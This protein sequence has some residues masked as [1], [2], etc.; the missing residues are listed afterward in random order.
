MLQLKN[1]TPFGSG[2]SVFYDKN[3]VDTLHVMVSAA[4]NISRKW[5]LLDEQPDP[6]GADEYWGDDPE[7]SSII[8]ASDYHIGKP[9]TDIV[10][11]GHA[12]APE[13]KK[14]SQLDVGLQ[15]GKLSKTIRVFGDRIWEDGRIGQADSFESIPLI[16]ERAFGGQHVEEGQVISAEQRNLVGCGYLGKQ[17]ARALDGTPVPNL[18]DPRQLL[19]KAGDVAPPAGFGF[20]SPGWEPRVAYAGTYDDEWKN[21]RA[22]FLPVDFDQRYLSMAHPELVYPGYL[23][24]GEEVGI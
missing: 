1:N 5:T 16:Y 14:V 7:T 22:P 23:Q 8:Y 13:G 6:V 17:K 19:Q 15:V 24:G 2:I 12:R 10:M 3:G 9:A 21:H 18:E 4:F 20:I 11:A